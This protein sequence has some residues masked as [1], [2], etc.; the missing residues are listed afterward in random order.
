MCAQPVARFID[1]PPFMAGFYDDELRAIA[2]SLELLTGDPTP[3]EAKALLA[4]CTFAV[5]DHTMLTAEILAAAPQLRVIVFMGTGASSYVDLAAAD[6]QNIRVRTIR[7][8]GDRTVAEHAVALMFAAAR[9]VATMDRDLRTGHWQTLDGLELAGKTLGVVG[10]G[11]IG[12]EMVRLG[13]ALGMTVLAWNRSG[14]ADGLPCRAVPLD[15]LLAGADVVSLHLALT[16]ETQGFLDQ[17]RIATMRSGA[18]LI[19][20]ARGGLIDEAALC[21]ALRSGHIGHAGLD[22]FQSEPLTADHPMAA[23]PNVTLTAHA[24]F[25][26]DASTKRLLRMALEILREE[27]RAAAQS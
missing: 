16:D 17:R 8:Y 11:G 10:T 18:L 25:M 6:G 4:D 3:K 19:N 1:C 14:V 7:G 13:A 9:Q 27:Q 5:L 26:T 20:T 22:V 12:R 15:D 23:M 21:A 2:P 24:G